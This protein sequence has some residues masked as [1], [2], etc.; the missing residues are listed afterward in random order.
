LYPFH[1]KE[2]MEQG[3]FLAYH[4]V[5]YGLFEEFN[6]GASGRVGYMRT[7]FGELIKW[8]VTPLYYKTEG[9]HAPYIHK[10][11]ARFQGRVLILVPT[12]EDFRSEFCGDRVSYHPEREFREVVPHV[13]QGAE[14]SP[15]LGEN[16]EGMAALFR[17]P[18]QVFEFRLKIGIELVILY[19]AELRRTR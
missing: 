1:F 15:N 10:N 18:G 14:L 6:G 3:M 7:D 2:E 13:A 12:G 11:V 8:N 5:R 17:A 4:P 16:D 9:R 19:R